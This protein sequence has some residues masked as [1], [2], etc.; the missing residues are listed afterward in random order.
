MT[1]DRPRLPLALA[2]ALAAM[3]L[4]LLVAGPAHASGPS[5]GS[6]YTKSFRVKKD[7]YFDTV[8]RCV[9]VTLRGKIRFTVR[10]DNSYT[11][12]Y[13]DRKVLRPAMTVTTYDNCSKSRTKL[14]T[15]KIVMRQHWASSTCSTGVSIGVSAP[16]GVSVSASPNCEKANL[17]RRKTSYTGRASSRTQYNSDTVVR[18]GNEH[19]APLA[20][21]R[22]YGTDSERRERLCFKAS[23]NVVVQPRR[24]GNSDSW[25]PALRPCVAW[26]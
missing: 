19:M 18:F 11:A 4:P 12:F 15:Y 22:G 8:N 17:A 25:Y 6:T 20:Y 16:W 13:R 3:L 1:Q 14:A 10:Y 26:W 23:A 9:R 2:T 7:R 21:A 24:L 5:N